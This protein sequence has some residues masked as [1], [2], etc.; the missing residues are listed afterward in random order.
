M[1]E[2]PRGTPG[3]THGASKRAAGEASGREQQTLRTDG[4]EGR[5]Q[6]LGLETGGRSDAETPPGPGEAS[7]R[8]SGGPPRPDA[9]PSVHCPPRRRPRPPPTPR[10]APERHTPPRRPPRR[11][12]GP[13]AARGERGP[14]S[15]RLPSASSGPRGL[16]LSA[17]I[18]PP[19]PPTPNPAPPR[20]AGPP[21]TPRSPETPRH[22]PAPKA[23]VL[24]A[25]RITI[26]EEELPGLLVAPR[27]RVRQRSGQPRRHL[28]SPHTPRALFP[29]SRTGEPHAPGLTSHLGAG[30]LG[31][32]GA[33]RGWPRVPQVNGAKEDR[34]RTPRSDRELSRAPGRAASGAST[35][36]PARRRRAAHAPERSHF[37][38]SCLKSAPLASFFPASSRG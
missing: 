34:L 12:A 24:A 35:R 25:T 38:P 17:S 37:E 31:G 15:H 7:T 33:G 13:G 27:H 21:P 28:L 23:F 9:Q 5:E 18:C 3:Q 19:Q 22:S 10:A 26:P 29:L 2:L 6:L 20:P 30:F 16:N 36:A 8:V 4:R 32:C 1:D 14:H 11:R